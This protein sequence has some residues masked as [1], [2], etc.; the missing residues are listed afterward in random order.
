MS[1]ISFFKLQHNNMIFPRMIG[2]NAKSLMV[3]LLY[4]FATL[5][6][7]EIE[8]AIPPLKTH[9]TDL[10]HTLTKSEITQLE[11]QLAEYEIKKG[12]QV[13][14]LLVSTTQPE[15]IEQYSMRVAE[16]WKLGRKGVDDAV[17]L[18]VAKNDRALRIEVGY[19]LEGVLPDVVAKR[20]IDE[21]IVP[22][23]RKGD[24]AAGIQ[25]GI[26]HILK[27]IE[28]EPLPPPSIKRDTDISNEP[29][30][31]LNNI[32]PILLLSLVLG[33]MLQAMFGRLIGA[34]VIGTIAGS[35]VWFIFSS[36]AIAIFVAIVIFILSLFENPNQGIYRGGRSSWPGGGS[37]GGGG[38]RGGGGGF[39]GGG[40]SGRW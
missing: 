3:I 19:G 32:I 5:S 11:Q 8:V 24:F 6:W 2:V 35:I 12:T 40:A 36:L 23:F 34:S 33:R 15:T 7:A 37:F 26:D 30:I 21:F 13:A 9:V 10:T 17:L 29:S 31:I 38:F 20:I 28:G 27:T 4:I 25:A 16:D 22:K 1:I 14:I 18:L 39:G